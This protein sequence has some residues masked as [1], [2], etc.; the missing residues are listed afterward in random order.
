MRRWFLLS[1][2]VIRLLF[3]IYSRLFISQRFSQRST[4]AFQSMHLSLNCNWSSSLKNPFD[5]LSCEIFIDDL[6]QLS[7]NWIELSLFTS[8]LTRHGINDNSSER[9][10][11]FKYVQFNTIGRLYM[12]QH[13]FV[14]CDWGEHKLKITEHKQKQRISLKNPRIFTFFFPHISLILSLNRWLCTS[15]GKNRWK[16]LFGTFEKKLTHN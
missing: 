7:H 8:N 2:T 4:F 16:E 12:G 3:P 9:H 15:T 6:W 5:Q 11:E 10:V 13:V 14:V 1:P